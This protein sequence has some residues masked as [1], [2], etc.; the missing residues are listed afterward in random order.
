HTTPTGACGRALNRDAVGLFCVSGD[1][2]RQSNP[3]RSVRTTTR[4]VGKPAR[5]VAAAGTVGEA[6]AT[7]EWRWKERGAGTNEPGRS[8]CDH[9]LENEAIDAAGRSRE[10]D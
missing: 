1:L 9:R 6:R 3:D 5:A 8:R 2:Y 7:R 10:G 4:P